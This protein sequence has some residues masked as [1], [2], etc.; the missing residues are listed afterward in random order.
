[1]HI[2]DALNKEVTIYV[3]PTEFSYHQVQKDF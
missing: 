2:S 3:T 1:M